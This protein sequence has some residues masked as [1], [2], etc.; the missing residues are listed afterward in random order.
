MTT[1][2]TAS[3]IKKC[4]KCGKPVAVETLDFERCEPGIHR[5]TASLQ[6]VLGVICDVCIA[7]TKLEAEREASSARLRRAHVIDE[8]PKSF[9]SCSFETSSTTVEAANTDAWADARAL[10]EERN[11]Y[12]AGPPGTGKSFMAACI[13]N[14][15]SLRGLSIA[16]VSTRRLVKVGDTFAEGRGAFTRWMS[17]DMLVLDDID[18][19][20]V[21]VSRLETL[22]ELFDY[23][24]NADLI[25]IVTSN[26][27]L[28][29][30]PKL[31][32]VDKMENRSLVTATL[33]RLQP[34][35][36]IT[37]LGDS[38]RGKTA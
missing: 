24:Y 5:V 31:F 18:K 1:F 32:G 20:R 37:L 29:F 16:M 26:V 33:D 34:V 30:L 12:I 21:S 36:E 13:L 6:R 27:P 8:M 38:L 19:I 10:T 25:T 14:R 15:A 22:W 9:R 2:P 28:G 7:R 4:T 35:E 11:L 17:A 23:R 3:E